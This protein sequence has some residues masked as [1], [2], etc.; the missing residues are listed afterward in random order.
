M[1]FPVQP[2]EADPAVVFAGIPI[3]DRLYRYQAG[4]YV[5][6][7]DYAP[8]EFG[9][10][11]IG[12][13]YWLF[14]DQ[15][16]KLTVK[17]NQKISDVILEKPGPFKWS[18]IGCPFKRPVSLPDLRVRYQGQETS[19]ETAWLDNGWVV[20]PLYYYDTQSKAYKTAGIDLF[21]DS[22]SLE[23]W[24]GYWFDPEGGIDVVV[25]L[26]EQD[27]CGKIFRQAENGFSQGQ[28]T[29]TNY[30]FGADSQWHLVLA[31]QNTGVQVTEYKD[32]FVSP[33]GSPQTYSFPKLSCS[34][35]FDP[36]SGQWEKTSSTVSTGIL[37]LPESREWWFGGTSHN[38][39]FG[40]TQGW[41]TGAQ[42]LI[43][44]DEVLVSCIY[45]NSNVPWSAGHSPYNGIYL[46]SCNLDRG[47]YPVTVNY[48]GPNGCCNV[49]GL[50]KDRD[51]MLMANTSPEPMEWYRNLDPWHGEYISPEIDLGPIIGTYPH[52][53]QVSWISSR[54]E[55]ESVKISCRT[56]I[57]GNGWTDWKECA[58]ND[59]LEP[60]SKVQYKA[61]LDGP[62][63]STMSLD[64][65]IFT[66]T[67]CATSVSLAANPICA[68]GFN[69]LPHQA[70]VTANVWDPLENQAVVGATVDFQ[71]DVLFS[72]ID[73]HFADDS[74]VTDNTGQTSTA[75]FSSDVVC[76]G[77]IFAQH[78]NAE[79]ETVIDIDRPDR[80]LT[81]TNLDGQTVTDF[82]T[83]PEDPYTI[84]L[85]VTYKGQPVAEH[86][87]KLGFC[88]WREDNP[89]L[90]PNPTPEQLHAIT[91]DYVGTDCHNCGKIVNPYQVT[92]SLGQCQYEFW[93]GDFPGYT[94]FISIDD[95]VFYPE[96]QAT[97][98]EVCPLPLM[99]LPR[100]HTH[101][102]N[103]GYK[104]VHFEQDYMKTPADW[105]DWP[106]REL[107]P[108]FQYLEQALADCGLKYNFYKIGPGLTNPAFKETIT[109]ADETSFSN[110]NYYRKGRCW[111]IH[112]IGAWNHESF[113]IMG[114]SQPLNRWTYIFAGR[115]KQ[116]CGHHP[117]MIDW[118]NG[119][120][121]VHEA[122]EQLGCGDHEDMD[123]CPRT[124]RGLYCV[125]L[126]GV[127]DPDQ[128]DTRFCSGCRQKIRN[129][130]WHFWWQ[131]WHTCN[132]EKRFIDL[133]EE[134]LL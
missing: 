64:K 116:M 27:A 100:R 37:Y 86:C 56:W 20:P 82:E 18:M 39:R 110:A 105:P 133:T 58:Q 48:Y 40:D 75:V 14:I 5:P 3:G 119:M 85:T 84:T 98:A 49:I 134:S 25:P 99:L 1:S 9:S 81:I 63:R 32:Y 108:N 118:L 36:N 19:F 54:G 38:W 80:T 55:N 132:E 2:L 130:S 129:N 7:F 35:Y 43:G 6:Y 109:G 106:S 73:A 131:F 117:E 125:M 102:V 71:S 97:L 127:I 29:N 107:R 34:Q 44:N 65:V 124:E 13:A 72:N 24:K 22:N 57:Y 77:K 68:G 33:F 46:T 104:T 59:D 83:A 23:P 17:G 21:D 128:V 15:P 96:S 91:P 123:T 66:Y 50:G 121:V 8:E 89:N 112:I 62:C 94:E 88:F 74:K 103:K 79:A 42:L 47:L 113:G 92:D 11:K 67:L 26:P 60:G 45:P 70:T 53:L 41:D 90:P 126:T 87:E 76:Q 114:L 10:I 30:V 122:G 78:C 111:T 93:A 16:I 31:P 115:I 12:E 52:T 4:G 120:T 28:R 61:V 51:Q 101:I 95:S 69:T